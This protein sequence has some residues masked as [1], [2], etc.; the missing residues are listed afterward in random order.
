MFT[1]LNLFKYRAVGIVFLVYSYSA[2]CQ[3]IEVIEEKESKNLL[4]MPQHFEASFWKY[5]STD[6]A[7]FFPQR[8]AGVII[9]SIED[10]T[11]KNVEIDKGT[12]NKMK[13]LFYKVTNEWKANKIWEYWINQ[14]EIPDNKQIIIPF[15]L[16]IHERFARDES[17]MSFSFSYNDVLELIKENTR[18]NSNFHITEP[19]ILDTDCKHQFTN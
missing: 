4:T 7:V 10:T 17:S 18:K 2:L 5:F 14:K 1:R 8:R 3:G 16:F 6:T 19:I 15:F 13:Q 11:V 12:S 9:I